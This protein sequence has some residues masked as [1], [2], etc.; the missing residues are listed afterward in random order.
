MARKLSD[1]AQTVMDIAAG[2]HSAAD[3]LERMATAA[4]K[5]NVAT[6]A[7]SATTSPNMI[8]PGSA[9]YGA[10][11]PLTPEEALAN[12]PQGAGI[13]RKQSDTRGTGTT[14]AGMLTVTDFMEILR[15]APIAGG[16]LN[17]A[18]LFGSGIGVGA[19]GD[20]GGAGAAGGGFRGF[21]PP[22]GQAPTPT[23]Q[24]TPGAGF[25][26]GITFNSAAIVDEIR[27][28]RADLRST[29]PLATAVRTR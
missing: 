24:A 13:A 8:P 14:N 18:G 26:G 19:G 16:R 2:S 25:P 3:G 4:D 23:N 21:I 29:M 9:Y 11:G 17:L 1:V 6:A 15:R 22:T 20:G 7:A 28:L 10:G 27:G 12:T 5:V